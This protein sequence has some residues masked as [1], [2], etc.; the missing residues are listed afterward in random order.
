MSEI[1][2]EHLSYQ[3]VVAEYWLDLRG[4]GLMI[5]P[6]DAEQIHDWERRGLPLAVVCR[7]L[8]RGVEEWAEGRPGASPPRSLRAVRF[9]VEGEWRAYRQ[10]RVGSSPAPAGEPEAARARLDAARAHLAEAARASVGSLSQAYREALR[11]LPEAAPTVAGAEAALRAADDRLLVAWLRSL[12]RAERSALGPRV[13]LLAGDRPR[14]A[15][16]AAWR[17]TLRSHL[18]DAARRAGLSCLRGSV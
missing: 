14:R 7:G 12:P 4:A 11:A 2:A 13:R 1:P 8:K 16:P 5:S 10:G 15:R 18:F 3:A 9:A 6:L 17:Q